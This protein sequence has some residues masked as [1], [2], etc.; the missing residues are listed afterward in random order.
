[1]TL[2]IDGRLRAYF[3]GFFQNQM[4]IDSGMYQPGFRV[5]CGFPDSGAIAGMGKTYTYVISARDTSG[6]PLSNYGS[7]TC[8][9]D[10]VKVYL[11]V[12][13]NR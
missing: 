9:A 7:V 5:V 3:S 13:V 10:V 8:P 4:I 11:P 6:P 2:T 12:I 1:M